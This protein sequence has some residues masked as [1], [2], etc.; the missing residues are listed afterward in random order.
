MVCRTGLSDR[1]TRSQNCGITMG[2]HER[3]RDMDTEDGVEVITEQSRT[4]WKLLVGL[5]RI[6]ASLRS[7]SVSL[8]ANY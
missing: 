7:K 1:V 6:S 8:H 3:L 5:F 2:D 4:A